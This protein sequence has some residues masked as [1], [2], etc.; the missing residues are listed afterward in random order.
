MPLLWSEFGARGIKIMLMRTATLGLRGPA[1]IFSAL[2]TASYILCLRPVAL[3]S[4]DL[5]ITSS[6]SRSEKGFGII[7]P[8][9][10]YHQRWRY[11]NY[12]WY[13]HHH[14]NYRCNCDI[15]PGECLTNLS[16]ITEMTRYYYH[17]QHRHQYPQS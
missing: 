7:T 2:G 17:Y 1:G 14:Q 6:K 3:H 16:I 4:G 11:H 10:P 9:S 15:S 12:D 5:N 13:Y 8:S